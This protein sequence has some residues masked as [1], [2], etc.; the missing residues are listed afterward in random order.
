MLSK[1]LRLSISNATFLNTLRSSNANALRS[2]VIAP[3][4]FSTTENQ[5]P[6]KPEPTPAAQPKVEPKVEPAKSKDP[7]KGKGKKKK[8][9]FII[10]IN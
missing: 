5:P 10:I 8:I 3:R 6:S 1:F 7:S 9:C 4:F 2:S